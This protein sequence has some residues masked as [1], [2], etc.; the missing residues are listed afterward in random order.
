MLIESQSGLAISIRG[1]HRNP[2]TL[3]FLCSTP[4][5]SFRVEPNFL[6]STRFGPRTRHPGS[7]ENFS[8]LN[9]RKLTLRPCFGSPETR[10]VE[11]GQ[12]DHC[13]NTPNDNSDI[14]RMIASSKYLSFNETSSAAALGESGTKSHDNLDVLSPLIAAVGE[15]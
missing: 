6:A 11:G 15:T 9:L 8:R 3:H 13:L 2:L 5:T 12:P 4:R 10:S 14:N 1:G 7:F